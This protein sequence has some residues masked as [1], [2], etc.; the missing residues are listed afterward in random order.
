MNKTADPIRTTG[1]ALP[2]T[3]R[4]IDG[5][6]KV[7]PAST[8]SALDVVERAV[9]E[10]TAPPTSTPTI[11]PQNASPPSV[12]G[13]IRPGPKLAIRTPL[14]KI[15]TTAVKKNIEA[16]EKPVSLTVRNLA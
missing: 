3:A 14:A 12:S 8:A 15:A 5:G 10:A 4:I 13:S 11:T 6:P 16:N 9:R 1:R 7:A 2:V